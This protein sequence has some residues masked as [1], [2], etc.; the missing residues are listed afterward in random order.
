MKE[1]QNLKLELFKQ[2]MTYEQISKKIGISKVSFSNKI[3]GRTCFTIDEMAAIIKVMH[4]TSSQKIKIFD[5]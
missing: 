3:N 1:L 2:K 5:L 4:L